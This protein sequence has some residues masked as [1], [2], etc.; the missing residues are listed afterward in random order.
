MEKLLLFQDLVKGEL[1]HK[2][3]SNPNWIPLKSAIFE[4]IYR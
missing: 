4:N 2:V 1:M 3:N